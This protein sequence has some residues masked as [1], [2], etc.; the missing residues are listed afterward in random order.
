MLESRSDFG[1]GGGSGDM[2]AA[3]VNA[4]C[5]RGEA[6]CAFESEVGADWAL[7]LVGVFDCCRKQK[8]ASPKIKEIAAD[9]YC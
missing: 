1:V 6:C 5:D 4:H 8:K 7:A 9:E 3:G 2:T